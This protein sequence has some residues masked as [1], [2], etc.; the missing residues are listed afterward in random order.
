MLERA[1]LESSLVQQK[2]I[3][4]VQSCRAHVRRV[5]RTDCGS[6]ERGAEV[7]G[8]PL[9][10]PRSCRPPLSLRLTMQIDLF[11]PDLLPPRLKAML[12][13]AKAR[14]DAPFYRELNE[15]HDAFTEE[16]WEATVTLCTA[17]Y[18]DCLALRS[19]C[20]RRTLLWPS[21]LW[22]PHD[23][24]CLALRDR[25][26]RCLTLAL[27]G[28]LSESILMATSESRSLTQRPKVSAELGNISSR[29]DS[30]NPT[31]LC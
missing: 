6:S 29:V 1:H 13:P 9:V 15:L 10:L 28:N 11:E 25:L 31:S 30:R 3:I 14:R 20:K 16:S 5:E 19:Y 23:R 17:L 21:F 22:T 26:N 2:H 12:D 27:A 18:K 7:P 4:R 8:T 24:Q